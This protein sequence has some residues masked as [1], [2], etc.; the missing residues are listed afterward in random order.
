MSVFGTAPRTVKCAACDWQ[1]VETPA[2]D[3][4]PFSASGA[5]EDLSNAAVQH[6]AI[7]SMVAAE[8][9]GAPV[10]PVREAGVG[11]PPLPPEVVT[12]AISAAEAGGDADIKAQAGQK[13]PARSE[14]DFEIDLA[15]VTE[16]SATLAAEDAAQEPWRAPRW[17][18][19]VVA[20]A[21]TVIIL[22]AGGLILRQTLIEAIPE[23]AAVFR[24]LGLSVEVRRPGLEI[25]DV[26]SSREWSGPEEVL[27]VTG[28]VA[29]VSGGPIA[30]P[31]LRIALNDAG[32][33][34]L[35]SVTVSGAGR[36]LLAGD[37]SSFQ[38]RILGPLE[39]AVRI[40]ITFEDR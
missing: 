13:S 23:S 19:A 37:S 21:A 39:T 33:R 25:R 16:P 1:W 40:K 34:E 9:G 20:I 28:T 18:V 38:A 35:Q 3:V 31:S 11:P 2:L 12:S 26:T 36:V 15:N 6:A 8:N 4:S 22:L 32:E 27:V 7:A 30:I 14:D 5:R 17:L 24:L 29:N 10:W